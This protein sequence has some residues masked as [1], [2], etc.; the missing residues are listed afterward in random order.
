LAADQTGALTSPWMS[1]GGRGRGREAHG[2]KT[3]NLT[4]VLY[5]I[6]RIWESNIRLDDSRRA[7]LVETKFKVDGDRP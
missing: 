1:S 6:A 4:D 5:V 3:L 7:M 2:H